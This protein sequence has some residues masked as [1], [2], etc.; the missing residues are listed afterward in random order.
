MAIRRVKRRFRCR[1][2]VAKRPMGER[3]RSMNSS[4]NSDSGCASIPC[5]SRPCRQAIPSND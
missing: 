5:S 3:N 4:P 2:S 1:R